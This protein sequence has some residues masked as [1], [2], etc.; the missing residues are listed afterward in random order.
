M[1]T[2][3]WSI[4]KYTY[5]FGSSFENVD[6]QVNKIIYM[7]SQRMVRPTKDFMFILDFVLRE[8]LNNAVE[9]GNSMQESELVKYMLTFSEESLEIDVY[10]NGEGFDLDELFDKK[11]DDRIIEDR[12]RGIDAIVK[13]GFL[14]DVERGHVGAKLKLNPKLMMQ[15]G[16]IEKMNIQ[17]VDGNIFCEVNTNLTAVNIKSLVNQF[18]TELE[19]K[20]EF[21]M[22]TMNL[23]GSDR[24]D[25]M[26]ITFLIGIHK[27]LA[28]QGKKLKLTGASDEMLQLFKIIKLDDV[29]E[30]EKI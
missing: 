15:E 20:G 18:K 6:I 30:I 16:L 25:S 27:I 22:V 4:F 24:I 7:L 17:L 10:D 26:G 11:Q 3:E 29:F 21:N 13:L 23:S 5:E 19:S 2:G 9:H 1:E 12:S 14:L 8:L 28:A